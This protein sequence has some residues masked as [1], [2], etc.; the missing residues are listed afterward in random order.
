[1]IQLVAMRIPD[2]V[3]V[4]NKE[5]AVLDPTPAELMLAPGASEIGNVKLED[6]YPELLA[7][8]RVGRRD[9]V[10]FWT[11]QM[12]LIDDRLS[13]RVGGWLLLP[14]DFITKKKQ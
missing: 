5:R 7:E 6:V 3:V 1:M 2:G 8:L 14:K 4:L 10:L 11:Y 9:V 13:E 12:R